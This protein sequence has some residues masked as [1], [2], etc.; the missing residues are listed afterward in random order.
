MNTTAPA[1]APQAMLTAPKPIIASVTDT[2]AVATLRRR[3]FDTTWRSETPAEARQA[4]KRRM[5]KGRS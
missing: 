2:T 4:L 1:A 5:E 3:Q